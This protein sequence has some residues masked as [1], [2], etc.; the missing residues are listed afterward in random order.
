MFENYSN[1]Y[2][3]SNKYANYGI[4]Q[5]EKKYLKK[6]KKQNTQNK[7]GLTSFSN[8]TINNNIGG[9]IS[10]SNIEAFG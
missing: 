10:N 1:I 2:K 9:L 3:D 8:S 7:Y 5:Q 6:V 4:L